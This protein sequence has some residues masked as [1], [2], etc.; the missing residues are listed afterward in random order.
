MADEN[1]KKTNAELSKE[2]AALTDLVTGLSTQIGNIQSELTALGQL[3]G[4]FTNLS[5]EVAQVQETLKSVTAD[6]AQ[7]SDTG[8]VAADPT[9]RHRD[10]WIDNVLHKYHA[11]DMPPLNY[12][13]YSGNA[14][15]TD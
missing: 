12:D 1:E 8:E 14:P 7:L 6:M 3:N 15:K 4:H 13:E 9:R 11:N 10:V 2:V 5:R